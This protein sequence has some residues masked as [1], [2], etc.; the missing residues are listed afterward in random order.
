MILCH[1][2]FRRHGYV[3]RSD[4]RALV[5]E[6]PDRSNPEV[7]PSVNCVINIYQL[8]LVSCNLQNALSFSAFHSFPYSSNI[9][10]AL[11]PRH[12]MV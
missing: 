6:R 4:G 5:H 7:A 12:V 1:Y 11:Y 3:F 9:T 2:Y 8:L 10:L